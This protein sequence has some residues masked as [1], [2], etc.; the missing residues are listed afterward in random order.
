MA[1]FHSLEK[2]VKN[3]Y[4]HVISISASRKLTI[5][6]ACEQLFKNCT[7]LTAKITYRAVTL[8]DSQ[9]HCMISPNGNG[10]WKENEMLSTVV[11][12][13]FCVVFQLCLWINFS[14]PQILA[15]MLQNL[16]SKFWPVRS[17]PHFCLRPLMWLMTLMFSK[18]QWHW[19][20]EDPRMKRGWTWLIKI[21][22][23]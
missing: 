23:S 16:F 22:L 9:G 17:P 19:Q 15:V 7:V 1:T 6:I 13:I 12:F 2:N 3:K 11:K 20:L 18:V 5:W 14:S 4:P 10:C 8:F 21:I